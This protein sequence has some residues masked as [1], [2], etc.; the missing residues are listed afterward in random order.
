MGT[1]KAVFDM[2]PDVSGILLAEV[3]VALF[4]APDFVSQM[5]E[6]IRWTLAGLLVALGVAGMA[7][8][9]NQ[10]RVDAREKA[11]LTDDL[12]NVEAKL[13]TLTQ[14]LFS[15]PSQDHVEKGP[16]KKSEQKPVMISA[17]LYDPKSLAIAVE[18]QSGRVAQGVTWELVLFRESDQVP[19]SFATQEIGYV[20]PHSTSAA[21]SMNLDGIPKA[22]IVGDSRL[23]D[24]DTFS[25][26]LSVDC[27]DCKGTTYIVHFVWGS[28]G[29]IYRVEGSNGGLAVPKD[30]SNEGVLRYIGALESIAKK[31]DRIPIISR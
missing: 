7:S 1:C 28:G 21:Y 5:K 4:I 9:Y 15:R 29:W 11:K 10:H 14:G 27:P 23:R 16:S 6:W 2:L 17:K 24:G 19:F 30:V 20:K 8:S 22:P 3:G 12:H 25:G 26:C 31:E 18:N 13:A